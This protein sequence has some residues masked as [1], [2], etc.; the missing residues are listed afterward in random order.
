MRLS[1]ICSGLALSAGM[2]AA[3]PLGI[4]NREVNEVNPGG[5]LLGKI[6]SGLSPQLAAALQQATATLFGTGDAIL[7]IVVDGVDGATSKNPIKD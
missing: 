2:A 7:K 1:I 6:I 4:E 3:A 5:L